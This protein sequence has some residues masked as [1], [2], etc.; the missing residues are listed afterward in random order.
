M[1]DGQTELQTIIAKDGDDFLKLDPKIKDIVLILI[2]AGVET[3]ASCQGKEPGDYNHAYLEPTVR[4]GWGADG[5]AGFKAL[6]VAI[7]H[8]L[9]MCDLRHVWTIEND[10]PIGPF[11]EMTFSLE[12]AVE[13]AP[14]R[15]GETDNE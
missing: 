5:A 3:F 13:R 15:P 8:G 12:K 9:P 2:Q 6:S 11:W 7:E 14:E 10:M 4:F 1:Q